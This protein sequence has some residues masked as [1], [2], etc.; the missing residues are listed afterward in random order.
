MTIIAKYR[1]TTK[2][3]PHYRAARVV[4]LGPG[5]GVIRDQGRLY[6]GPRSAPTFRNGLS[7]P[8]TVTPRTRLRCPEGHDVEPFRVDA[9]ESKTECGPRCY[10]AVGP[11]CDCKCRGMNHGA[12]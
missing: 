10:N 7:V 12:H 3:C 8:A 6:T 11:A 5:E 9:G 1:C 4:P 2:G